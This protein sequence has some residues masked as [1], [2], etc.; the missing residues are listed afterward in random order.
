MQENYIVGIYARL[1]RDDERAGESVSIENQK[2]MLSRYVREQGWTLYDYYCDDGV[3]GTTFDRPGLN[4]LVQDATDHK[5]NLVLCKDLSRLGR[6]YIEAGKYTDF[7]FPSLGCRFIALNDGV[8]TLRK[9]ALQHNAEKVPAPRSFYYMAEGRENLRGET[10]F[11]N[12]VTVKTIL[13]NEVYIGHMVQNKTGTV[14][15]KNHKQV[16]KPESEWIKVENTHE[17]LIPQETWDAV[18]RMDN[19]PARGRSGKNGTIALFGGLLRCMDCGSSMRYMRD[20]RKKVSEKEPEYKAYVCNRY[21]SGGKN[22]CSSHYINQK[23]L[24]QIVMTDIRCKAMWAQNSRETLRTQLL[25]REQNASVERTRTLQAELNAIGKRL[26]ELD[27]LIQSA[28]EDKV[29]GRIPESVCVNLLNQYEAERREKQER[30]KE[31]TEQLAARLETESSVDAWLDM[32]QDY[33]QLEELDRPT[34]VRLIQKIE[35]SERYPV[36]DHEERDIHIYYNF[37]GYIEA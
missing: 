12:D 7:V 37:V 28:Y 17:P 25:A 36:D 33:A 19:H 18:Q 30:R 10:P 34:L 6:D 21:A 3:S 14:S 24:T 4:R 22:A 32:M 23:V 13:R 2:E 29:L 15:Y 31:L 1:S 9:I 35:I 27:K 11:W 8:D 26:P 20:Y 16:S 5:I